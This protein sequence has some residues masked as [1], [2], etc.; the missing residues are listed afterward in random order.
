[1]HPVT[2]WQVTIKSLS[3]F[4]QW[5]DWNK[6]MHSCFAVEN[7]RA[8]VVILKNGLVCSPRC[9]CQLPQENVLSRY[10]ES[11]IV[12]VILFGLCTVRVKPKYLGFVLYLICGFI[13]IFFFHLRVYHFQAEGGSFRFRLNEFETIRCVLSMSFDGLPE[14]PIHFDYGRFLA[15]PDTIICNFKLMSFKRQGLIFQQV[16]WTLPGQNQSLSLGRF[17]PAIRFFIARF[18]V[19]RSLHE[20]FPCNSRQIFYIS[21]GQQF[22]TEFTMIDCVCHMLRWGHKRQLQKLFHVRYST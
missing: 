12:S 22:I 9:W 18:Q 20:Y 19:R 2:C 13:Q 14:R 6:T 17:V 11:S 7:V 15:G 8:N 1:M 5:L 10:F 4:S 3:F 16:G 21:W